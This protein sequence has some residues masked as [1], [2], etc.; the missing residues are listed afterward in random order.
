MHYFASSP[1]MSLGNLSRYW[2][3]C[4]G[5]NKKD[6]GSI[7]FHSELCVGCWFLY[8]F[9]HF[10]VEFWRCCHPLNIQKIQLAAWTV[11]LSL[12]L[13]NRNQVFYKN[14]INVEAL[15][16]SEFLLPGKCCLS[17][18]D[19]AHIARWQFKFS[20]LQKLRKIRVG[21]LS[22]RLCLYYEA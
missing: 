13:A 20:F 5:I 22:M 4:A 3:F 15:I 17:S 8:F 6:N 7:L 2:I 14:L 9:T 10:K 11:I 19:I 1:K 16:K 12:Y 21:I 18:F